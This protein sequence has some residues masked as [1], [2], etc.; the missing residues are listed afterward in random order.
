MTHYIHNKINEIFADD[1]IENKRLV[2]SP[3]KQIPSK[4]KKNM[5]EN[6]LTMINKEKNEK[7]ELS[8]DNKYNN[9][10]NKKKTY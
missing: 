5:Q 2:L 4:F 9:S 1:F 3:K 10:K 6:L 7:L 8:H